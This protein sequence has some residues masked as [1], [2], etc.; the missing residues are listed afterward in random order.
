MENKRAYAVV[1][2]CLCHDCGWV[3]SESDLV[4]LTEDKYDVE[5]VCCPR[6]HSSMVFENLRWLKQQTD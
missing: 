5:C 6:C 4:P 1:T 2:E 3:G